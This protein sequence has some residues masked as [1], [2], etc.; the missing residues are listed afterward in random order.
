MT[1][2]TSKGVR[3]VPDAWHAPGVASEN[4]RNGIDVLADAQKLRQA[5]INLLLHAIKFTDAPNQVT[6]AV[7]ESQHQV[8]VS[9]ADSGRGIPA[10]RLAT[11]FDAFT[12]L[13]PTL[14]R[15]TEGIGL[16]L[17]I[18]RQLLRGMGSDIEVE[19]LP[20]SGSRFSMRLPRALADRPAASSKMDE[21]AEWA[22]KPL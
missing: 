5:L 15:T 7:E 9:I 18:S 2:A 8:V 22:A 14:T 19:N 12:Q 11:I 17:A 10:E 1:L 21:A 13:E 20:G 16:G 4:D 6:I 3:I